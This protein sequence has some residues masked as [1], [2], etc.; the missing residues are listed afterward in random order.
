METPVVRSTKFR[1]I[2]GSGQPPQKRHFNVQVNANSTENLFKVN[3]SY[4]AFVWGGGN[5]G[6]LGVF[7]NSESG[8]LEDNPKLLEAFPHTAITDFDFNPFDD[9]TILVG[10][11]EGVVSLFKMPE[12]V[13]TK[14]LTTPL[15]QVQAHE[16]KLLL[17]NWHPTVSN[18]AATA[19]AEGLVKLWDV[20][21][22]QSTLSL[23]AA[24]TTQ[25]LSW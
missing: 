19:G 3:P 5:G 10:N 11:R 14:H 7:P 17:A 22:Q 9:D 23:R 24:P 21:S 13:L 18:L 20:V 25:S 2:F 8:K 6:I 12:M 1:H 4:Y 16:K 15:W